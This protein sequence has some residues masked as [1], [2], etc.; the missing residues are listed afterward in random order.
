MPSAQAPLA[1]SP[2]RRRAKGRS[3]GSAATRGTRRIQ[4]CAMYQDDPIGVERLLDPSFAVGLR[5][6]YRRLGNAIEDRCA[7]P[8]E[9]T[10]ASSIPARESSSRGDAPLTLAAWWRHARAPRLARIELSRERRRQRGVDQASAHRASREL[11]RR[12]ERARRR[13]DSR[14]QLDFDWPQSAQ[15]TGGC[16]RPAAPLRLDGWI[17]VRSRSVPRRSPSRDHRRSP[18]A[19]EGFG[20]KSLYLAC[21]AARLTAGDPV[22]A[23]L[24]GVS[25]R[26]RLRLR[27]C[28]RTSTTP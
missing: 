27:R 5:A 4:T 17:A 2:R 6:S 12:R 3:P 16:S 19:L 24:T 11:R 14:P 21:P 22:E 25:H 18:G 8:D 20:D 28:R 10:C 13:I 7:R 1:T 9:G 26:D 15:R 23:S